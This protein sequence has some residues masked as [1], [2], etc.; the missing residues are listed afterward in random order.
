MP[1]R[2]HATWHAHLA[3]RGSISTSRLFPRQDC[4][5]HR[6][7]LRRSHSYYAH[8][9][10]EGID[11]E[12][13]R[14]GRD[15][16]ELEDDWALYDEPEL[17]LEEQE[18]RFYKTTLGHVYSSIRQPCA[19]CGGLHPITRCI[20]VFKDSPEAVQV[21]DTPQFRKR[22]FEFQKRMATDQEFHDAVTYLR[23]KFNRR[24]AL[25][26]LS[27]LPQSETRDAPPLAKGIFIP[28]PSN[29]SLHQFSVSSHDTPWT[30]V[31]LKV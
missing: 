8:S 3:R 2:G 29:V 17:T 16:P 28:S 6:Q 10:P 12:P 21:K 24:S 25:G 14:R 19:V 11:G 23:N 30:R 9:T 4:R 20:L 1:R 13:S 26:F 27:P 5:P 15:A 7:S 22:R 31:S 18:A